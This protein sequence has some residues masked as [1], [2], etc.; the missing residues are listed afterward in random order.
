MRLRRLEELEL[1]VNELSVDDLLNNL[2]GIFDRYVRSSAE[3]K[4]RSE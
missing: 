4:H 3:D 1:A 2:M